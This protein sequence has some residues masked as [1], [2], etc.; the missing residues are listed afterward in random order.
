MRIPP[1]LVAALALMA[2]HVPLSLVVAP[3]LEGFRAPLTSRIFHY[4][5]PSAWVAY[6]AF[7]CTAACSAWHLRTRSPRADRLARAHAEMGTLFALVA[8]GTGLVWARQEFLGYRAVEDPQVIGLCVLIL[9]YLGYFALRSGVDDPPRRA[10]LAG[11]YGLLAF[12]GVPLSYL[13]S[14]ASIHPDFTR[15]E[16][17][18]AP[19]L[20][21]HLLLGALT[22]T[23]LHFALVQVR[24]R[25]ALVEDALEQEE[26][27]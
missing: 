19:V 2:L 3:G 14:K 26:P 21:A 20:W 7:A 1:L 16:Q 25:L 8:L 17:E 27:T 12:I 23:V 15:P 22:F 11:V 6:L 10:R 13:A 24:A 9:A 4:H 5:V 18:L